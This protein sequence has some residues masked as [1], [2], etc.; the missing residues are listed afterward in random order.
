MG[1]IIEMYSS[2]VGGTPLYRLANTE[3]ELGLCAT[4]LAKLEFFNP[5]GSA[6]DRIA[7][8]MIERAEARGDL[9]SGDV[10]IEPTSGNTGIALCA[11]GVS[12][13]YRVIIVMPDNMSLERQKLMRAY[14]GEVVLTDGALG[15]RGSID[16]AY[17]LA[18][19][20]P[21]AFIPNQFENPDNPLSHYQSTAEELWRDTDGEIDILVSA[22]GT[23]GTLSG[24]AAF[25]K[26]KKPSLRV[27]A[28]EPSASPL[29]S[30]GR[31]GAHSISGIGAN[32]VPKTL[33]RSLIDEII[34]V[35][36][37]EAVEACRALARREGLLVGISSGAALT[38][39]IKVAADEKN[40][41]LK[42]AV[43]L[44]D[45]G[46]RYLSTQLFE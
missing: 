37:E 44:P 14:G 24:C 25:L 43:I 29:L 21:N 1:R 12:R 45:G 42:I 27:V 34:T 22:V 2:L 46:E 36:E 39:A 28:V 41:G 8:G 16:K 31:A 7:L 3:R 30:E 35:S 17:E 9:R 23:G 20:I 5:A 19:S 40:R 4:L 18:S 11:I 13:G 15:M 26:E 10:I 33:N 6:K 38:A 32:F